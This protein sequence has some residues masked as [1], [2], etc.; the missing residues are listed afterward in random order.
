MASRRQKYLEEGLCIR[1]NIC[2]N[3]RGED[4]TKLHCRPCADERAQKQ[5]QR[6]SRLRRM[7][8]RRGECVECGE[9]LV[10]PRRG[11]RPPRLCSVHRGLQSSYDRNRRARHGAYA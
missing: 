8:R 1:Y 7:R 4:G 3:E 6:S 2:G 11:K 9:K 5:V 10:K